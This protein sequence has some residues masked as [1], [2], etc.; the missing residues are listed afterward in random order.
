MNHNIFRKNR[1]PYGNFTLIE[2]LIVIAIIAILAAMLLP[3]LGK[4]RQSALS[5]SCKGNLKQIGLLQIMYAE[6]YDGGAAPNIDNDS[7]NPRLPLWQH[8]LLR[9]NQVSNKVM[10]C[11]AQSNNG[12]KTSRT[13]PDGKAY[14][15]HQKHY[16]CNGTGVGNITSGKRDSSWAAKT[17]IY[18]TKIIKG[19]LA[20]K[21]MISDTDHD[22]TGFHWQSS[23]AHRERFGTTRHNRRSNILWFDGHVTDMVLR[24][25][26]FST[27]Y[28][29][30]YMYSEN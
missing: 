6:D 18:L 11:P 29:D 22:S 4:A 12:T 26:L 21:V 16:T 5:T 14:T 30:K 20:E 17:P 2:L 24:T 23:L 7:A 3:A 13:Y 8:T 10:Y 28:Y 19:N 1:V 15:V 9:L 25:Q 27:G